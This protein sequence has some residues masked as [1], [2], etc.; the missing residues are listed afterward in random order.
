MVLWHVLT[1]F[2]ILEYL[3]NQKGRNLAKKLTFVGFGFQQERK[4]I[5][6]TAKEIR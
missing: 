6:S 2:G 5:L 3:K 1:R 4:K